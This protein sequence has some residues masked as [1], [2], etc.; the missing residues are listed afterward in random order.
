MNLPVGGLE[1][2]SFRPLPVLA[3]FR[4][5]SYRASSYIS[6]FL[7]FFYHASSASS[8]FMYLVAL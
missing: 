7:D 3:I 1:L 5:L 6:F 4:P 8:A 2:L